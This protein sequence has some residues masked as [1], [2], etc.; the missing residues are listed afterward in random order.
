VIS[1]GVRGTLRGL[2]VFMQRWFTACLSVMLLATS[3][4]EAAAK[5]PKKVEAAVKTPAVPTANEKA[6]SELMGAWKWGMTI[7]EVLATLGKQLSEAKAPE[8]AKLTDVYE[9]TR[10][11]KAIKNDVDGVRKTL[12]K[13][14][15]QRTGWDVS[16]IEGEFL[17]KN[18][19]SMMH[20]R[21]TDPGTGRDQQRFFFFHEGRLWKQFI[22]FNMETYK[23]KTFDDFRAAMESRYGKG[24]PITK[25]DREGKEKTVA[26][27]W[28]ASNTYLRA[29]DLM[30]FYAN[31]CL[32]FS[33]AAVEARMDAIRQERQSKISTP[34]A[35]VTDHAGEDTVVDPNADVIDRITAE[36][37]AGDKP[38]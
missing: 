6:V 28:R 30:Q 4:G 34:R 31:F 26:V 21:E 24:R 36:K 15:G 16:I 5:K 14:E 18:G 27:A 37:P 32:A 3:P 38:H 23:G 13:F 1:Q 10:I 22:A 20:Y 11:R 7:D 8:L 9:Q 12:V 25:V 29:I 33:D 17:H 35:S 19:E 2:E